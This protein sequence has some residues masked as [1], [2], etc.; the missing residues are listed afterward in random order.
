MPIAMIA[1]GERKRARELAN[2]NGSRLEKS[3]RKKLQHLSISTAMTT[4]HSCGHQVVT[5]GDGAVL[6]L[7]FAYKGFLVWKGKGAA[8]AYTLITLT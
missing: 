5:A 2:R 3:A 1:N 7:I 4:L 6:R 8:A